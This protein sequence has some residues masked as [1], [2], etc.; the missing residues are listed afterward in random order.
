M[1]T[2]FMTSFLSLLTTVKIS[3]RRLRRIRR[4]PQSDP[5]CA[6]LDIVQRVADRQR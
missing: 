2:I 6:M 3:Y 5:Q 1:T 4:R